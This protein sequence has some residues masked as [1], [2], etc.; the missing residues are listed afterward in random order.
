MKMANIGFLMACVIIGGCSTTVN[1]YPVEGPLSKQK[2]LAVLVAN[3]DGINTNTGNMVL[4]NANGAECRGRWSSVAPQMTTASWGTLFTSY[5]AISGHSSSVTNLPGVNRG[6]AFLVC[7]DN[8]KFDI[9]FIT[10]SGTANGT[11]IAKDSE[12][13]VY[14]MIF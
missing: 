2:S 3:A 5:G 11:G 1:F 10:G 7:A 9:E 6:Q 13:N 14:K 12:G 4:T 8:V